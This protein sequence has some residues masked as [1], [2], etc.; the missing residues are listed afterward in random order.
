[1][2]DRDF[3][4]SVRNRTPAA[5]AKLLC[6]AEHKDRPRK[7]PAFALDRKPLTIRVMNPERI[8]L[9]RQVR[10]YF[11][12]IGKRGGQAGRRELTRAQARLMVEI[13]EAKRAAKKNGAPAPKLS[14]KDQQILR[15]RR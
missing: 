6:A 13:R 1:M 3:I 5:S 8:A 4:A 10:E 9:P 14:R 11:A 12:E 2:G 7:F 15:G